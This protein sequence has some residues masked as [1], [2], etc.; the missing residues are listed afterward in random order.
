MWQIQWN[1]NIFPYS[2]IEFKKYIFFSKTIL[3]KWLKCYST[4]EI[5]LLERSFDFKIN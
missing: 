1:H 4:R 5:L 2:K 3:N